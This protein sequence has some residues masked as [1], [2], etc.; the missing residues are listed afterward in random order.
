MEEDE[1]L[2]TQWDRQR[3][4]KRLQRRQ[5][6]AAHLRT[7]ALRDQRSQWQQ[8]GSDCMMYANLMVDYFNHLGKQEDQTYANLEK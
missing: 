5:K 1:L 8:D 3:A 7:K 6:E 4:E 2:T